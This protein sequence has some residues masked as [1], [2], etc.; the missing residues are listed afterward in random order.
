MTSVDDGSPD[1]RALA[2]ALEGHL[3]L[4]AASEEGRRAAAD[5]S[6]PLLW[7]TGDQ[8][9]ELERRFEAEYLA[10]ARIS[11]QRTAERAGELR[12]AYERRYRKL[13]Q[14]LLAW[15]LLGCATLTASGLLLNH[16]SG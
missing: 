8:R 15:F 2:H 5:F 7:L 11:W 6:A 1:A 16:P 13:R 9:E 10:C 4:A 12:Q 3:L 14:R